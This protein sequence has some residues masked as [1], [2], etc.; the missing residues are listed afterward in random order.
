[1]IDWVGLTQDFGG[2]A[3]V[4]GLPIRDCTRDYNNRAH[5]FVQLSAISMTGKTFFELWY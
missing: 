2:S 1:M 3:R 5:M 4:P